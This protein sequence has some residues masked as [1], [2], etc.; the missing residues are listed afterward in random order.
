MRILTALCLFAATTCDAIPEAPQP[1]AYQLPTG[2][3]THSEALASIEARL[4]GA[5]ARAAEQPD[6]WMAHEAV[7]TAVMDRARLTGSLEDYAFAQQALALAFEAAP[8]S[9]PHLSQAALDYTL[10]RLAE[11][12]PSLQAVEARVLLDDSTRAA[13]LGLRGD[14]RLQQ[15]LRADAV[16]LLQEAEAQDPTSRSASRL[17]HLHWRGGA[18]GTAEQWYR[19]AQ[20]RY[21]GTDPQPRA[22]VHLQLGLIDLEYGR[23]GEALR[24]Y[25]DAN[26]ELSGY[27]LVEE[28]VAEVL[29]LMGHVSEALGL[30]M[31]II[32]RTAGPE[33]MDAVAK[34]FLAA[35]RPDLARPHIEAARAIYQRQLVSFPEASYGHALAHFL[36]FGPSATAVDLAENNHALR[37]NGEASRLLAEAYLQDDQLGNA[38]TAVEAALTSGW[39]SPT[40]YDTAARVYAAAGNATQAQKHRGLACAQN[41]HLCN[42]D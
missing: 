33:F 13:V 23:Y 25:L 7:A 4:R 10:H 12:E 11:V 24:H 1:S 36:A 19:V 41:P 17:A 31:D 8:G 9:G 2:R 38:V 39:V 42:A 28:H 3:A 21:H 14:L 20:D 37:P 6:R 32:E 34:I 22:W 40:L 15:G 5:R 26:E 30:Y 29:Y 27:Y 18:I 35:Q 16:E